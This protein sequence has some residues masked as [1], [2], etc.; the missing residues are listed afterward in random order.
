MGENL[1]RN[2]GRDPY[3]VFWRRAQLRK[4]PHVSP[5]PG[6]LEPEAVHYKP[7]DFLV[8]ETVHVYG[9]EIFL[10]DCDEFTREF[11]KRYTGYE[12]PR[13]FVEDPKP[14]RV[15]LT[16]PPHTG[17]GTEEDSMASCLHLTPRAPRRDVNKLMSDQGKVLRFQGQ[18]VNGKTED[19]NR[20]FVVAIYLADDSVGVWELRQRNSGHAEG[21]FA[22]KAKKRNPA[23]G[24]WFTPKDFQIG[25]TVEINCTP[26]LLLRGDDS[27][28]KY[29]EKNPRDFP[30]ADLRL[31]GLKLVGLQQDLLAK[32][33]MVTPDE[34]QRLAEDR[35]GS[36]LGA[37]E[38]VTLRRACGLVR[39]DTEVEDA[40][41]ECF[42]G[43]EAPAVIVTQRLIEVLD[44][45][46]GR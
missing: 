45:L 12:Q 35:L 9:R 27:T 23:T 16:Y 3:P 13:V 46:S 34:L 40:V 6:M 8:G 28:L 4:N 5:A 25:T 42:D 11:F 2:S 22:L 26:F 38:M 24:T 18:M 31:I 15:Q 10:Y 32:G 17:F 7:E 37:H 29:M 21:K 41:D 14:V 33:E 30:F 1:P 20:R 44:A 19:A 39:E 43:K 36:G